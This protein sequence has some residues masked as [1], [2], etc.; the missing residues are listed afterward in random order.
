MES[1]KVTLEL[2]DEKRSLKEQL[3]MHFEG[4]MAYLKDEDSLFMN[5][6]E[7]MP[8]EDGLLEYSISHNLIK[9]PSNLPGLTKFYLISTKAEAEFQPSLLKGKGS[10]CTVRKISHSLELTPENNILLNEVSDKVVRIKNRQEAELGRGS[11]SFYNTD[12]ADLEYEIS[13]NFPYLGMEKPVHIIKNKENHPK[14][15]HYDPPAFVK[16]YSVMNELQGDQI[17]E[18]FDPKKF[19]PFTIREVLELLILP[20]LKAYK[21]QVADIGYVHRDLKPGNVLLDL[22]RYGSE[23]EKP[24][25]C[26]STVNIID[27]DAEMTVKVGEQEILKGSP[28][29]MPPEVTR[30]DGESI[31]AFTTRQSRDIFALGIILIACIN[32]DLDP[33]HYFIKAGIY[34]NNKKIP[35]TTQMDVVRRWEALLNSLGGW[36]NP[37]SLIEM[38][39]SIQSPDVD[40]KGLFAYLYGADIEN[41][42]VQDQLL[43]VLKSMT[44]VSAQKRFGIDECI[45]EFESIL[46][47]L[48]SIKKV[49]IA[50]QKWDNHSL[51]GNAGKENP[52]SPKKSSPK[53]SS[54]VKNNE[55][56]VSPPVRA[57]NTNTNRRLSYPENDGF[58]IGSRK[59]LSKF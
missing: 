29:Y 40:G 24:P 46:A 59:S 15:S 13:S 55:N 11:D 52:P 26:Q 48:P 8:T 27:I 36:Y 34:K 49:E 23:P 22:G 10:Y 43:Q 33:N 42:S 17:N 9:T 57:N 31:K 50:N 58:M 37:D 5:K 56:S 54:P 6:S 39:E 7:F 12:E 47:N 20:L 14:F 51:F 53:K 45:H 19:G 41:I 35:I 25:V 38:A 32:P 21:H 3:G 1:R 2:L 18:V 4:Y 30:E 16:S 44:N 28:A